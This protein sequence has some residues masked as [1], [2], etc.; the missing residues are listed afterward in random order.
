MSSSYNDI[1]VISIG[2]SVTVSLLHYLIRKCSASRCTEI[3]IG[4]AG[5]NIKRD[6]QQETISRNNELLNR[7]DDDS[8]KH[9]NFSPV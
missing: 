4:W 9:S 5:I 6:A 2:V 7:D 8:F 3:N 1:V